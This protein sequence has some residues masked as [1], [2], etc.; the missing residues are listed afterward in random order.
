VCVCACWEPSG[1]LLRLTAAFTFKNIDRRAGFLCRLVSR[2]YKHFDLPLSLAS[3][4][5]LCLQHCA[6]QVT[7]WNELFYKPL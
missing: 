1:Q 4:V 3:L 2:R 5:S 7:G 6:H